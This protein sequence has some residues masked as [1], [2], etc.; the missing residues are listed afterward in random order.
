MVWSTTRPEDA[1]LFQRLTFEWISPLLGLGWKKKTLE[2]EDFFQVPPNIKAEYLSE[3]FQKSWREEVEE[4]AASGTSGKK[5]KEPSLARAILRGWGRRWMVAGAFKLCSDACGLGAPVI[6]RYFIDFL[7]NSY[8]VPEGKVPPTAGYGYG[9]A[10]GLFALQFLNAIFL[11]QFWIIGSTVG[12]EVSRSLITTVYR[13]SLT[14][15]Q[16]ARQNYVSGKLINLLSS[17]TYRITDGTVHAH[18]LWTAPIQIIIALALLIQLLGVSAVVGFVVL[19]ALLPIAGLLIK[20]AGDVRTKSQN[21]TDQRVKQIE[22]T[23]SGIRVI[24]YMGW[25]MALLAKINNLRLTE[26][27]SV[28]KILILKGIFGTIVMSQTVFAA[29]AMFW[30]YHALGNTLTSTTGFVAIAYLNTIRFPMLFLAQAVAITVEASVSVRRIYDLLLSPELQKSPVNTETSGVPSEAPAIKVEDADFV[31]ESMSDIR[32]NNKRGISQSRVG[33]STNIRGTPEDSRTELLPPNTANG[34]RVVTRT[35][36]NLSTLQRSGGYVLSEVNITVPR[37]AL[38]TVVGVV[39]S[40]KSSLLNALLG[41]MRKVNG[42]V[43]VNGA[44]AYVPQ[45]AWIFNDSLRNNI[46]FGKDLDEPRYNDVIY[47]CALTRDLEILTAGDRTE[48]GE[49]GINLSGGQKQRINL[50]RA[51]YSDAPIVIADDPLS[52]VDAHVSR[53]IF[54]EC[55]LGDMKKKGRTVILATHQLH[56]LSRSD[57]VICMKDGSIIEQGTYHDLCNTSAGTGYLKSLMEVYGGG[58][59][60]TNTGLAPPEKQRIKKS[61]NKMKQVSET[62]F[63]LPKLSS[64]E[65]L[66][67]NQS[68]DVETFK[69][70]IVAE[71]KAAGAVPWS[72]YK[73]YIDLAGGPIVWALGLGLVFVQGFRLGTDWW[74]ASYCTDSFGLTP[75]LYLVGYLCWGTAQI[76]FMMVVSVAGSVRGYE[77]AKSLHEQAITAILR[78]PVSFFDSTP[79]GRI[80]NR[81]SKDTEAMDNN[82]PDVATVFVYMVTMLFSTLIIIAVLQPIFLAPLV[83]LMAAY[84]FVAVYYRSTRREIVRLEALARSP[85]F[86]HFSETLSGLPTIRAY[87]AQARLSRSNEKHVNNHTQLFF[88]LLT[89][90]RWLSYRLETIASFLVLSVC[91]FAVLQRTG[92]NPGLMALA[93]TYILSITSVLNFSVESSSGLEMEFIGI[94]RLMEYGKGLESEADDIIPDNRP[95]KGWPDKGQIELKNLEMRYRPDLP[96]VLSDVNLTIKPGEKI[97]IVG[98]TGAGKSSLLVSIFR[99]VEPSGGAVFIDNIDI[100]KIGLHDLRSRL[101]IIAQDPV[102]FSGTIR[103]NL[104]PFDEHKDAELWDVLERSHI[105][106]IVTRSS[107][108]LDMRVAENGENLSVGQ[109]Q[110]LCLARAM[111]RDSNIVVLDEATASV[112]IETDELIQKTI[113]EDERFKGR[114]VITIAHRLNTIIDYDRVLVMDSG[115]ITEIGSPSDLL[116]IPGGT[117]SSLVDETGHDN[118]A[119]LRQMAVTKTRSHKSNGASPVTNGNGHFP[120]NVYADKLKPSGGADGTELVSS[121]EDTPAIFVHDT[122][123]ETAAAP[124]GVS[125]TSDGIAPLVNDGTVVELKEGDTQRLVER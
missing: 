12:M 117:F 68:D 40:G 122:D 69:N 103:S 27:A 125:G 108:K 48:I 70:L 46:L 51:V 9:L 1:N 55:F 97:G 23:L 106:K 73:E 104:D 115:R 124:S 6:L 35:I 66:G 119:M 56:V 78:S 92:T 15:S 81:F 100:G 8:N 53:H 52:A 77:G 93:A 102:V 120:F 31:W 26:L 17:D 49:R 110:L 84:Y 18:T 30:V 72:V 10:V 87:G 111:L 79:M 123:E 22:E 75:T 21:I 58:T 116:E 67:N 112:D 13:K 96:P 43:E 45:T 71:E 105:K 61:E 39:G 113:R 85:L 63:D 37:G 91:C 28:R 60:T 16:A 62:S 98:R 118:A 4:A 90:A 57:W 80:L 54:E 74:L 3:K 114:T 50:A 88:S 94:S 109:R 95:P 36:S 32:A 76:L 64:D 24:K 82:V 29:I 65:S 59:N 11:N 14:L 47:N 83:P 7:S 99:L 41:E 25:E 34:V 101:S 107:R 20:Q 89:V 5:A 19:V 38:V 42:I 44:V 33:S 121:S 2:V 86:A